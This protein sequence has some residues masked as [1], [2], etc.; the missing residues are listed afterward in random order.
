MKAPG[1]LVLCVFAALANGVPAQE[2]PALAQFAWRATISMPPATSAAQLQIPA[3]AMAHFKTAT[4]QDLRVFNADG[5]SV[6]MALIS[7]APVQPN[8]P[9]VSFGPY[10]ALP[11]FESASDRQQRGAIQVQMDGAIGKGRVWVQIGEIGSGADQS[12][13]NTRQLPAVL[14]DT[15][16]EKR[17]VASLTLNAE[18][19]PNTLATFSLASSSDLAN[20][21]PVAVKGPL[22]RFDGIGAPTNLTLELQQPLSLEGH[23][24]RLSWDGQAGIR[25]RSASGN[26]AKARQEP[27]YVGLP[28]PDGAADAAGNLSW[29][30]GFVAPMAALQL[31]T[32]RANTLIPV[33]VLGRHEPAQ[34]WQHLNQ[35]VVYRV[36]AAELENT[37]SSIALHNASVTWLRVEA[38]HGMTL[39]GASL[40]ASALFEPLRLVFVASG[41]PPFELAVGR[42]NTNSGMVDAAVVRAAFAGPL[43]NL[44]IASTGA[45]QLFDLAPWY[46]RLARL[47]SGGEVNSKTVLWLVLLLGVAILAGVAYKLSRQLAGKSD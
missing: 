8:T 38:T 40:R 20:W 18:I 6:A 12:L 11:L 19:A 14:F 16:H 27:T 7:D 9:T 13:T 5:Q 47:S 32:D 46:Q 17:T 44:P 21:T 28:L 4:R 26:P 23:Y 36:G 45:G 39:N 30:T 29:R 33:R 1:S 42:P 25:V 15:R 22:F 10:A 2:A 34:P 43:E 37:N 35:A 24:L 31:Q 41:K 3:E